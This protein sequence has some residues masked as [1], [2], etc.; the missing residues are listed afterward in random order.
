[1]TLQVSAVDELAAQIR[2]EFD[3]RREARIMD[4]VAHQ[5]RVSR[6]RQGEQG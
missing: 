1:L 4:A 3:F 5:F 6:A 2:L